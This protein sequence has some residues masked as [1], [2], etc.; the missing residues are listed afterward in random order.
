[1]L[2]N[3]NRKDDITSKEEDLSF[4]QASQQAYALREPEKEDRNYVYEWIN[5]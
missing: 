4:S 3:D 5:R 1:M 2:I